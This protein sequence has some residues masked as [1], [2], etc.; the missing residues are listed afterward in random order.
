M[1]VANQLAGYASSLPSLRNLLINGSLDIWQRGTT[2]AYVSNNYLADRFWTASTSSTDRSTD[3]PDGFNYSI[4]LTYGSTDMAIGQP[5]ELFKTGSSTPFVAGETVTLSYYAKVDSGT[6]AIL[7]YIFFRDSKFSSTNQSAFTYSNNVQT[8]TTSWQRF[9]MQFTVPSVNG[10]NTI[11]ALEIA[12]ISKTAYFTG[13]QLEKGSVAT[14]I[15]HRPIGLELSLC[16]RYY[17][18]T[19][20]Q[21]TAPAQGVNSEGSLGGSS[22]VSNISFTST[23]KLPVSMRTKPNPITTYSTTNSNSNWSDQS[24]NQPTATVLFAG[25][26]SISVRATTSIAAGGAHSIHITAEAEL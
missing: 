24:G 7:S 10:T 18:K 2:N 20:N 16:Q 22:A 3:A 23:M 17:F 5:I 11:A 6:E 4:K 13:F 9:S 14:P 25:E 15:E 8:L 21:A 12:G 1:T 19:F 26:N